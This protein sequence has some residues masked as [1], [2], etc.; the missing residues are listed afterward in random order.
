MSDW[1]T[2]ALSRAT[3]WRRCTLGRTIR[4]STRRQEQ[5]DQRARPR[6]EPP[7]TPAAV[8]PPSPRIELD[9]RVANRPSHSWPITRSGDP[10]P[11]SSDARRLSGSSGETTTRLL[12]PPARPASVGLPARTPSSG[13]EPSD[14]PRSTRRAEPA[15]RSGSVAQVPRKRSIGAMRSAPSWP[16]TLLALASGFVA[17]FLVWIPVGLRALAARHRPRGAGRAGPAR[18]RCPLFEGES[19]GTPSAPG[20]RPRSAQR[21]ST[22]RFWP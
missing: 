1:S 17:G 11:E 15:S 3:H 18:L 19:S 9:S 4:P 2:A 14:A 12:G 22:A 7:T 20:A 6:P 13:R 10:E 21:C 8:S 16:R 5:R